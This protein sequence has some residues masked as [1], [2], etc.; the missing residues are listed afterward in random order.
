MQLLINVSDC[1]FVLFF[2]THAKKNH[3]YKLIINKIKIK[4]QI[5]QNVRCINFL[6]LITAWA[7]AEISNQSKSL[8]KILIAK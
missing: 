3:K 6:I 1:I 8:N 5:K 7:G 2:I 4:Y